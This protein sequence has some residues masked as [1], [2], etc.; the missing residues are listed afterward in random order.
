VNKFIVCIVFEPCGLWVLLMTKHD[1]QLCLT[2]TRDVRTKKDKAVGR[3]VNNRQRLEVHSV[4]KAL[5]SGL[6]S[7]C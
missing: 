7:N 6:L 3:T 2:R 1:L 4:V 5:G